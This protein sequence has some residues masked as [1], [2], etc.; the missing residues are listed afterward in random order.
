M[1]ERSGPLS[2]IRV[3]DMGRIMAAPW[4]TQMLADMGAD[5]IKIERPGAGDDT[6]SWGPPFL[7]DSDGNPTREAGYYLSVNRGKRSATIDMAKPEGQAII[8][9]LAERSDIVIENFKAGAL[10]R[11]GLDATSLRALKPDLIYC[12]VTG[13]GQD[14]P[15]R[16]Q[17]AY[18]FAIQAMGG[19][20]SVTG[21]RDGLPGGGP[22]K[23]GVPVVD[24]MTG[25]YAAVAILAALA[26][27]AETGQGE[28]IDLAMLDV[29]AAF[30][31]NQAMN[32]LVSGKTPRRGGNR[33]PNIQPQDVFGASDGHFVLAVGNDG[34][35]A[36]LSDVLGHPEWAGDP[37]FATNAARVTANAELTA[38]LTTAFAAWTQSDIVA[39]LD[40]AGVPC[41]P[42]ND[43]P[44]VF[45]D[46]Q[47]V[48][49]QMLRD[50]PHPLS[51]TV[52]QVVSPMR[53]Q[54]APLRFDRAPPLLGADND[55]VLADLGIDKDE[56][57]GLA[58]MGVI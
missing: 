3:L 30:L 45:Q 49:R 42:I 37:R 16:D 51:G 10:A 12:S 50:L 35:F 2:H 31:G 44:Q 15:R 7:A 17:A 41:A 57:A 54:D 19:L 1:A 23:V 53:F 47:I 40:Q 55:A 52:P 56:R 39:A 43:V 33:H 25:M 48:H 11:Y 6:R 32:F 22:Q 9:R 38:L 34:Q 36:K 58:A 4:A 28:T 8:R 21:E 29:A 13:F 20:M 5:V 24:L 27:R 46:P 18:D 14:G 26:R